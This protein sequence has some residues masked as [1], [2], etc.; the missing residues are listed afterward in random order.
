MKKSYV[1]MFFLVM[2][3]MAIGHTQA[4]GLKGALRVH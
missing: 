2:L 4:Q 1:K 3:C